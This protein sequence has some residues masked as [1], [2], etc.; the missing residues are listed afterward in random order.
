MQRKKENE[1]SGNPALHQAVLQMDGADARRWAAAI[2]SLPDDQAGL[3]RAIQ[4]LVEG[5]LVQEWIQPSENLEGD[6]ARFDGFDLV[7]FETPEQGG[8]VFSFLE[9]TGWE[10]IAA[11]MLTEKELTGLSVFQNEARKVGVEVGERPAV[12]YRLGVRSMGGELGER[13]EQAAR[14]AVRQLRGEVWG[15]KPGLFSKVFCDAL[16]GGIQVNITPNRAGL[17]LLED[18]LVEEKEG[19][20]WLEGMVFQSLCDFLGVVLMSQGDVELQWSLCAVEERTG[21]APPPLLRV[22]S[23]GGAW[24][25]ESVGLDVVRALAVPWREKGTRP[26]AALLT[27]YQ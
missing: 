27:Q 11:E 13:I 18:L 19:I 14:R 2:W 6:R 21:L 16:R 7:F 8:E 26:L 15:G 17:A 10:K 5:T 20:Y 23:R 22:R 9:E 12:L 1:N 3:V 4:R 25:L 24:K